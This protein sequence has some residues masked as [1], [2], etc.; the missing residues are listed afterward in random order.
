MSNI[1]TSPEDRKAILTALDQISAF[2][3]FPLVYKQPRALISYRVPP[4]D[5][6]TKPAFSASHYR[7]QQE[8][9]IIPTNRTNMVNKWIK[10]TTSH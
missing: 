6:A 5:N 7:L 3:D 10:N 2:H 9:V 4:K 1:P 8:K